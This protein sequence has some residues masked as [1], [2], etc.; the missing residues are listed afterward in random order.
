M[1]T[2]LALLASLLLAA[3]SRPDGAYGQDFAFHENDRVCII[4]D[5]LAD[6]LRVNGYVETLLTI[7]RPDL[8]LTFRN[9]G[10]SGDTLT[11]QP[12]PLNF[13][14]LDEHLTRQ[15]ADVVLLCFGMSESLT[16]PD[17][18]EAFQKSLTRFVEHLRS[19]NYNGKRPPRVMIVAPISRE[20]FPLRRPPDSPAETPA[21][22]SVLRYSKAT[23]A[24]AEETE[25][26]FIDLTAF[27][28]KLAAESPSQRLTKNGIHLSPYGYWA[29]SHAIADALLGQP[30]PQRIEFD[31]LSVASLARGIGFHARFPFA[32]PAPPADS[33]VH[34]SLAERGLIIKIRNMPPGTW[35]L[36]FDGKSY[37]RM[38]H[39]AF[40]E[41][42]VVTSSP[43][44]QR[45]E[46]LRELIVRKNRWFFFRFR[47]S[48]SEY[49]FGRRTK[50]FGSESFPPEMKEL[51]RLLTEQD[52]LI[53]Q[54]AAFTKTENWR[55]V[56][57][58]QPD[59]PRPKKKKP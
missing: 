56:R 28:S 25:A 7:R 26:S 9:L 48:N 3:V 40:T 57:V 51:D 13:G 1:P 53:A 5:T 32:V 59:L 42:V 24:A 22:Q 33:T 52:E 55:L 54:R 29:I 23:Q 37:Q 17:G 18:H 4:G 50:P 35:E 36:R 39:T 11:R 19:E 30:K 8:K 16:A 47:P 31:A 38:P 6:Q 20:P 49:V 12:R 2:R 14:S 45:T 34:P 10:W 15:K 58:D 46:E 27:T 43:A 21:S 44:H 41:G